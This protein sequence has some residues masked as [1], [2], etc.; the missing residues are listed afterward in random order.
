MKHLSTDNCSLPSF[1][2]V[3]TS[4]NSFICKYNKICTSDS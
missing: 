4:M 3:M 1:M 2:F